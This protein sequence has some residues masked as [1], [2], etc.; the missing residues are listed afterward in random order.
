M[1]SWIRKSVLLAAL[2]SSAATAQAQQAQL[3]AGENAVIIDDQIAPTIA[4]NG[5]SLTPEGNRFSV[6]GWLNG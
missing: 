2:A 6:R 3:P 4:T 5:F 1:R